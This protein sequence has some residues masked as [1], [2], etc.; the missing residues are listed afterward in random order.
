MS[1]AEHDVLASAILLTTSETIATPTIA[2][3]EQAGSK[4]GAERHHQSFPR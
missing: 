4:L 1:Q 2:E 3:I